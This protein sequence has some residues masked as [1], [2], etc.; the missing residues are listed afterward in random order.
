[1]TVSN[2]FDTP[3]DQQPTGPHSPQQHLS[4]GQTHENWPAPDAGSRLG[5]DPPVTWNPASNTNQIIRGV[6]SKRNADGFD[7]NLKAGTFLLVASLIVVPIVLGPAAAYCGYR[8]HRAGNPLGQLFT[9][10]ALA[11]TLGNMAFTAFVV[12]PRLLS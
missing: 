12:A 8:S 9:V 6:L 1:M 4:P 3:S 7:R 2:P 10:G 11:V 5:G